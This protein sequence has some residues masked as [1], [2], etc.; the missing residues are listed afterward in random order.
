MSS[1][2]EVLYAVFVHG[3][4]D[5]VINHPDDKRATVCNAQHLQALFAAA[6]YR[7]FRMS[8]VQVAQPRRQNRPLRNSFYLREVIARRTIR[9][10]IIAILFAIHLGTPLAGGYADNMREQ[11]NFQ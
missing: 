6:E 3:D 10:R 7:P 1:L 4:H 2:Q 5:I 8:I 11:M 9:A